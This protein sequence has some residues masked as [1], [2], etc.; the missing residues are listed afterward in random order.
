MAIEWREALNV[1]NDG[2]DGDH[3]HMFM[4]INKTDDLLSSKQPCTELSEVIDQLWKYTQDHFSREENI[5]IDVG[6]PKYDQHKLAHREL[7]EQL[8]LCTSPILE[9]GNQLPPTTDKLSKAVRDG[10]TGLLRHWL[11]D[12]ILKMDLQL[13]PLLAGRSKNYSP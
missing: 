11:V 13:K 9:M 12:H 10:L 4:L 3:K 1:G 6:Y 5:M 8:R 7:I 2:I